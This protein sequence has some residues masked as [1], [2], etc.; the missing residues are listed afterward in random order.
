MNRVYFFENVTTETDETEIESTTASEI[1][2]S[3]T[4]SEIIKANI[5]GQYLIVGETVYNVSDCEY[6][7]LTS[8]SV[9]L[10][11][12]DNIKVK[13]SESEYITYKESSNNEE[14]ET[15]V[16]NNK[17]TSDNSAT[18]LSDTKYLE[19]YESINNT[20]QNIQTINILSLALLAVLLG[21]FLGRDF[22]KR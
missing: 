21:Y 22:F 16:Q 8:D 7:G 19:T 1:E 13:V 20:V 5:D 9:I 11:T 17:T 3:E 10:L 18:V 14:I 6:I 15:T 2:T 12:P 4:E